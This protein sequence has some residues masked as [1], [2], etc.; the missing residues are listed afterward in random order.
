VTAIFVSAHML[1]FINVNCD[2]LYRVLLGRRIAPAAL[3]PLGRPLRDAEDL[4]EATVG[5]SRTVE[6]YRSG[7]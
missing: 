6:H 4:D 3:N 1:F 7:A 2:A 5:Q